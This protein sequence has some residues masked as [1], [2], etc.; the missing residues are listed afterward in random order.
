MSCDSNKWAHFNQWTQHIEVQV[1]EFIRE[2]AR[3][4]IFVNVYRPPNR[5]VEIMTGCLSRILTNIPRIDRK[6][7][8]LMG[9]FNVDLL[10]NSPDVR[11]LTRF[12]EL[13][14]LLQ[15]I[16][17]PTR[18]TPTTSSLLDLIARLHM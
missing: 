3:N 11:R 14:S 18:V 12:R 8:V 6:D 10:I 9:D 16:D 5:V 13:N 7:L 15:L 1:V 2:K 17:V 4:I